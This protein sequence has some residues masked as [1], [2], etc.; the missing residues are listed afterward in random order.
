MLKTKL[1]SSDGTGEGLKIDDEGIIGVVIHPHPPK[2]ESLSTIPFRQYFTTT[3]ISSG[4]NDMRVNGATTNVEFYIKASTTDTY[5]KT[6]FIVIADAGAT[7]AKF[8][9]LSAL[10][11]GVLFT[12]ETVKQ[13]STT[14]FDSF[15]INLDFWKLTNLTPAIV[16]LSAGGADANIVSI[17]LAYVF[18]NPYGLRLKANS[19]DR[20]VMK[21][22]DNLSVG[23]DEF[24][25][26]GNGLTF[27]V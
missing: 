4:S 10:S 24:N 19:V 5:I 13:G 11:N 17:D 25:I 23:I 15:K 16:D 3:G 12:W 22:R 18:G 9:A 1:F 27:L 6:I 26:A 2:I 8:G 7:L 20:L 14:L 21:V